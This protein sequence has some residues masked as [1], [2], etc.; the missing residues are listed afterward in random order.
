M[1]WSEL[2]RLMPV[3]VVLLAA[4]V[5]VLIDLFL[6]HHDRYVLP[7]IGVAGCA[8][9]LALAL[10]TQSGAWFATGNETAKVSILGGAFVIDGFGLGV[11]AVACIAGALSVLSASHNHEDSPLS[12]GEFYGLKLLAVSGMMLLA[13]SHDL[14]TLL[15]SLEIMSI[16]T[17]ILAGSDHSNTRSNEAALKYLVLGAFSTAFMLMGM[18]FYYGATGSLSLAPNTAAAPNTSYLLLA[19][20]LILAGALFKIGAA[21]FHFWI[22]DVYEGAP[23][24]VTGLMAVGVKAAAFAVLARFAFE[25]FGALNYWVEPLEVLA[26]LTMAFGNILA[27]RQSNVKRMLAYSGIAHT[28]YLMLALLISP[29]S[30][31]VIGSH[32]HAINFYLL[33]YGLM[34]LGAF[35]VLG[36]MREDG[37]PLNM[38]SDFQGL[39]KSHP[40][41]ALCMAIFM[42]SLAGMPPFAGF[43]AKF[44]I[45]RGAIEQGHVVA[46][47]LGIL[48]SVAS[49]YYYLRVVVQMYMSPANDG[50]EG[51]EA[52]R[53]KYAWGTNF[54]IYAAGLGT[55]I[56]GVLPGLAL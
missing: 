16:S 28:G 51:A 7:W 8:V 13:V 46:A 49:L 43:F 21:P 52:A 37:R 22:P 26:V 17:Y 31:P 19:M 42:L 48:T 18:A 4:G 33:S 11:W 15:I 3:G 44:M 40:G 39:A 54:L 32:L 56:L 10:K 34:T 38:M 41:I 35:G 50:E 27:M 6:K 29:A 23:S 25:S 47:V 5:V 1:D 53:C 2:S 45:F 9:A 14:L 24:S 55:L 12:A 20:G 36:L 30:S